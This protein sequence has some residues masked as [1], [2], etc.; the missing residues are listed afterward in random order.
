MI[1]SQLDISTRKTQT[2]CQFQVVFGCIARSKIQWAVAVGSS[3]GLGVSFMLDKTHVRTGKG[4]RLH[5]VS[6]AVCG[7]CP[8]P[9]NSLIRLARMLE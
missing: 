7:D 3:V 1:L 9:L 4:Y 8:A 2:P 6:Q 5:A